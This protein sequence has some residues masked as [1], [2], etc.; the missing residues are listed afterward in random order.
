MP[1][2]DLRGEKSQRRGVETAPRRD[3]VRIGAGASQ[4]SSELVKSEGAQHDAYR[5]RGGH[6][7]LSM[8]TGSAN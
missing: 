8:G 2:R 3:D 5:Q 6:G 7:L 4:D 1:D